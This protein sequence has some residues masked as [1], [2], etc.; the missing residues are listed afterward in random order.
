MS[1]FGGDELGLS[2]FR[3]WKELFLSLL[4]GVFL[5]DI[6]R[7]K[8]RFTWDTLDALIGSY[9]LWMIII[10]YWNHASLV[11]Y[12]YGLRYDAEFLVAFVFLRRAIPLWHISFSN[13]AK[14][15]LLSG[16]LMLTMSVLIRYIFGETLLTLFGFNGVIGSADAGGA[17]PIYHDID[18]SSIIRFQGVLE[19]P[20]QMAF[21]LLTYMSVYATIF[22]RS[23][24]TRVISTA[25]L[26]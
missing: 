16:G 18:G 11:S 1:V 6:F 13:L 5:I 8:Y 12:V 23:L 24:R 17:P 7:N 4:I 9:I 19:G 25:V 3:F 20:N 22:M 14:V 15:F 10:S 26:V 2:V 21:F